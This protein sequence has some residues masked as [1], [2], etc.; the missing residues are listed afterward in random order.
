MSIFDVRCWK[1]IGRPF[2]FQRLK[3]KSDNLLNPNLSQKKVR[4]TPPIKYNRKD[5]GYFCLSRRGIEDENP[6]GYKM[7]KG[8]LHNDSSDISRVMKKGGNFVVVTYGQP[9]TRLDHFRRKR[10]SWDVDHK[11]VEK[12]VFSSDSSPSSNYHV[13]CMTKTDDIDQEDVD[14]D[15]D[16]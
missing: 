7:G 3:S 9:D 2:N 11:T 16:E 15:D 12:P 10:L 5:R 13:Y 4:G 14:D 8:N 6:L 1:L